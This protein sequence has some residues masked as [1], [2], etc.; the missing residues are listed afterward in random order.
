MYQ[1]KE[2]FKHTVISFDPLFQMPAFQGM[3]DALIGKKLG[4]AAQ[5]V[6]AMRYNQEVPFDTIC[7]ICHALDCQPGDIMKAIF[8][9][10]FPTKED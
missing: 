7:A 8:A 5:T 9:E 3:T 1:Y 4:I 2:G 10:Y 6:R